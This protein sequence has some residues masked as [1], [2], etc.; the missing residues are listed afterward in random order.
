[1][2]TGRLVGQGMDINL[3]ILLK[4]RLEIC[5]AYLELIQIV[6]SKYPGALIFCILASLCQVVGVPQNG[7]IVTSTENPWE[8]PHQKWDDNWG[9]PLFSD[10]PK[11]ELEMIRPDFAKDGIVSGE[12]Y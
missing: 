9:H 7:W 4:R 5:K 3:M 1:M 6:R 10:N 2:Y 12:Q 8:N 11:W